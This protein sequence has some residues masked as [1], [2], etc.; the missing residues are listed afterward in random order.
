MKERIARI[1]VFLLGLGWILGTIAYKKF[2]F[3]LN[4]NTDL[5][6]LGFYGPG[7][8]AG[9]SLGVSMIV[10]AIISRTISFYVAVWSIVGWFT[11][12]CADNLLY[13]TS[14]WLPG[15][16]VQLMTQEAMDKY[17]IFHPE[18]L[19]FSND[20]KT[21]FY[22][23]GSVRYANGRRIIYDELGYNN[24]AGYLAS[25]PRADVLILGDSFVDTGMFPDTLRNLLTPAIVYAIGIGGQGPPQW[26]LHFN[27]YI[28]SAF[29]RQPPQVVLLNFYSG[30][31]VADS[32]LFLLFPDVPENILKRSAIPAWPTRKLSFFQELLKIVQGTIFN[33]IWATTNQYWQY[34]DFEPDIDEKDSGWR[35]TVS[36]LT[37]MVEDIR[38]AAPSA[39]ILLSYQST[40][41]AIYG[42]DQQRCLDVGAR[43]FPNR[44]YFQES[45]ASAVKLQAQVSQRLREWANIEGVYY[46]DPT[47]DLQKVGRS[48][49]LHLKNDMHL[50]LEG[51]RIYSTSI[52]HG[53]E[54]L[55]LLG[56]SVN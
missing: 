2:G 43:I 55:E 32:K 33:R 56:V 5:T 19:S 38:K 49:V 28:T 21:W 11:L 24:P 26:R 51:N 54:E 15:T 22:I 45:C 9:I 47:P 10:V 48:S 41:Q 3:S 46:I 53:I 29:Y 39:K 27:R 52:M 50:N 6:S 12:L 13:L 25:H 34:S 35:P 20:G 30:N 23:P 7:T 4:T 18:E 31:D 44:L 42:V 17:I 1:F 8:I 36:T 14:P 37:H 16:L 40:P